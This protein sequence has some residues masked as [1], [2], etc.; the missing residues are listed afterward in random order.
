MQL[1]NDWDALAVGLLHLVT[2]LECALLPAND[3]EELVLCLHHLANVLARVPRQGGS[4]KR[5]Q[6]DVTVGHCVG[7]CFRRTAF[8]EPAMFL[9][10]C[11]HGRAMWCKPVDAVDA[12]AHGRIGGG[13]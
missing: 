9:H 8:V 13:M 7:A 11:Q 10:S 5:G 12:H 6:L 1:D 2:V 4:I 3:W